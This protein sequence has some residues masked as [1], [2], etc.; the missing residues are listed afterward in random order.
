MDSLASTAAALRL[1]GEHADAVRAL[2]GTGMDLRALS[3]L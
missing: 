2:A 1:A 3:K